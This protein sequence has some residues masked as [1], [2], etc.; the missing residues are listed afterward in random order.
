MLNCNLISIP[1]NP[2]L[3]KHVFEGEKFI[4]RGRTWN[5]IKIEENDEILVSQSDEIGNVPSWSGE[6]IP[7]PFE[8]A[9]EVGSL[10]RKVFE[11]KDL[12]KF[13]VRL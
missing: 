5:I 13:G 10:R 6:D 3:H 9:R 1:F 7:V 8:V 12:K 4:L 2:L 11:K